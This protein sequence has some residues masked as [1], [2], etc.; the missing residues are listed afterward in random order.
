M[1]IVLCCDLTFIMSSSSHFPLLK[2]TICWLT[3]VHR[4]LEAHEPCGG[5]VQKDQARVQYPPYEDPSMAG[6]AWSQNT[7]VLCAERKLWSALMLWR[8]V[9]GIADDHIRGG[10]GVNI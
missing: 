9:G 6:H 8:V 3:C 5:P 1:Q 2:N 7:S 10:G 4:A